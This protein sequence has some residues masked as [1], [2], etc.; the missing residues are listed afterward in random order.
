M[1]LRKLVLGAALV[2]LSGLLGCGEVEG[3]RE[4]NENCH[5]LNIYKYTIKIGDKEVEAQFG[6]NRKYLLKI[7][8]TVVNYEG[9]DYVVSVDGHLIS[10]QGAVEKARDMVK[11]AYEDILKQQKEEFERRERAKKQRQKQALYDLKPNFKTE[12]TSSP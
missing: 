8:K 12:K 4:I 3:V 9:P 10:S 11:M 1:S 7:G 5:K 6:Y 2:G